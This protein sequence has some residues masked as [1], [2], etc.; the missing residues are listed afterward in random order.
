M[1]SYIYCALPA[2]LF[3]LLFLVISPFLLPL[4]FL[5]L[6]FVSIVLK[7]KDF[8]CFEKIC[9]DVSFKLEKNTYYK[10]SDKRIPSNFS[11]YIKASLVFV[12]MALP[13][14]LWCGW[15]LG[16]GKQGEKH[17]KIY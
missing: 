16:I 2:K 11:S 17:A 8:D 7:L 4:F 5:I 12:L 3:L 9:R 10:K 1:V 13:V 6:V 14:Q 15:I